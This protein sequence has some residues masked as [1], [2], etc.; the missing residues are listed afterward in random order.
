MQT[1]L[2]TLKIAFVSLWPLGL[3]LVLFMYIFAL[4]GTQFLGGTFRFEK[5][6]APRSNFDYFLPGQ[7]GQGAFLTIFQIISTENW[8]MVL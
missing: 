7:L 2:G 1:I 5:T 6:D 3:V 4:L 8:N